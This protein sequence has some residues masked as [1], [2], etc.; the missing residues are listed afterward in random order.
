[1]IVMP[2]VQ[3]PILHKVLRIILFFKFNTLNVSSVDYHR[4]NCGDISVKLL[5]RIYRIK[6]N[7]NGGYYKVKFTLNTSGQIVAIGSKKLLF[8]R[9]RLLGNIISFWAVIHSLV[10]NGYINCI[11]RILI[12]LITQSKSFTHRRECNLSWLHWKF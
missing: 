3:H 6:Y 1:M 2:E 5:E 12:C 7:L 4:M 9:V 8:S 10:E 11:I